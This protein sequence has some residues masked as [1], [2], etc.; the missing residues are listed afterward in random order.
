M[1]GG[2]KMSLYYPYI[3]FSFPSLSFLHISPINTTFAVIKYGDTSRKEFKP[4]SL[5]SEK[6]RR[7]DEKKLVSKTGLGNNIHMALGVI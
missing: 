2:H 4:R 3:F 7:W 1:G 6:D 5:S